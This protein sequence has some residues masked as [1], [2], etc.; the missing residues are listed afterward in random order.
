MY[1]IR[2]GLN[3]G[4]GEQVNQFHPYGGENIGCYEAEKFITTLE[5]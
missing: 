4:N 5:R 3:Y 1:L 2:T